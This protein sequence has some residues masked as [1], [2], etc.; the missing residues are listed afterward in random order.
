MRRTCFD[1]LKDVL[2]G[3]MSVLGSTYNSLSWTSD[4]SGEGAGTH[5][6]KNLFT[7]S[8]FSRFPPLALQRAM[9]SYKY[10]YNCTLMACVFWLF[11]KFKFN[12]VD[13]SRFYDCL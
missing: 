12:C 2:V 1:V 3:H 6:R 7:L 5:D 4:G 10:E 13:G 9:F 11:F 8:T